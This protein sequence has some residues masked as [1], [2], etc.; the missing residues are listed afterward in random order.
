MSTSESLELVPDEISTID[1]Y[2]GVV[3]GVVEA[4]GRFYLFIMA[5]WNPNSRRRAYVVVNLD[6][7]TAAEMKQML[8]DEA[9]N[10]RWSRVDELYNQYLRNYKGPA[11]LSSEGPI[12]SKNPVTITAITTANLDRFIDYDIENAILDRDLWFS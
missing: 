2:D 6:P 7:A 12:S 8:G 10:D 4:G 1:W 9:D 11:Y 5:A 3:R